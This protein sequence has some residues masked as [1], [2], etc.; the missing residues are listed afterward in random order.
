M[1]GSDS[2]AYS[3]VIACNVFEYGARYVGG[4]WS[5]VFYESYVSV[6][7]YSVRSSEAEDSEGREFEGALYVWSQG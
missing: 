1:N 2:T 5:Y 7:G 4:M 6:Y 3:V